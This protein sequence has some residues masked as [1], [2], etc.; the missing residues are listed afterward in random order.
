MYWDKLCTIPTHWR[1]YRDS[2]MWMREWTLPSVRCA[3]PWSGLTCSPLC[4]SFMYKASLIFSFNV[5][6]PLP[7]VCHISFPSTLSL[8]SVDICNVLSLTVIS[9]SSESQKYL[10]SSPLLW[11]LVSSSNFNL[12]YLS[13][14]MSLWAPLAKTLGPQSVLLKFNMYKLLLGLLLNSDS[15]LVAG[16]IWDSAFWTNS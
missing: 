2:E 12:V 11:D 9:L 5:L 6:S 3:A 1:H 8:T 14:P 15:E 13:I 7:L 16:G 4:L 10:R